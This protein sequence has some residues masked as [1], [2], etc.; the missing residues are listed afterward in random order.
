MDGAGWVAGN[1]WTGLVLSQ[2]EMTEKR[3]ILN[4]CKSIIDKHLSE[5]IR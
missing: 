2:S 5:S 4:S 3:Q 1:F